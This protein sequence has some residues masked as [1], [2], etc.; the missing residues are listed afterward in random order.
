MQTG[1][2][3]MAEFEEQKHQAW[4]RSIG[5]IKPGRSVSSGNLRGREAA[6]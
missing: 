1:N 6:R 3:V 2:G 4:V 5:Q